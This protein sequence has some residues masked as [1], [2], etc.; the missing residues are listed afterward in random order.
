MLD[1][2]EQG[3][4]G[5]KKIPMLSNIKE[6]VDEELGSNTPSPIR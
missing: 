4:A 6:N 2:I 3:K 1:D 5:Q